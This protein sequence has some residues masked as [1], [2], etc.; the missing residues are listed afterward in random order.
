MG[1]VAAM[2]TVIAH[3]GLKQP[4]VVSERNDPNRLNH[5]PIKP[6][7]RH[8][9]NLLYTRAKTIVL[10][11]RDGES[12]FPE[13]LQKKAMVIPNPLSDTLPPVDRTLTREKTVIT[14]GRLTRQKNHK[15][16]M[17][18]FKEFAVNH[19]DYRLNIFGRGEMEEELQNY[20][21]ELSMEGKITLCGFS[22]DL[23]AELAKGGIYVSSSDWE[24]ISNSLLEAL[25]MGIPTIATD[26]PMGGS[27][28]SI[29]N[30][31]NGLLIPMQNKEKLVEALGKIADDE[32]FADRLSRAGEAIREKYSQRVILE[33]W[34]EALGEVQ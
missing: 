5:Q 4:L 12:C 17:D 30:G 9:R 22:D 7:V 19:A 20:I 3:T 32:E 29:R 31:E 18:S 25:A 2:F 14:A 23:Y 11:T 8:I 1:T 27:R 16:L 26:C 15:L 6:V 24:G 33:Q 28:M 13:R 21:H 34:M 10:Q